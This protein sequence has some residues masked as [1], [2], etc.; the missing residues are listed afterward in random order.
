MSS[1]TCYKCNRTGHIARQCP[2]GGGDDRHS[3]GDRDGGNYGRGGGRDKCYKCNRF[4]H[5]ARD[6][7]EEQDRFVH[8]HFFMS[9]HAIRSM[10]NTWDFNH[11]VRAEKAGDL[12]FSVYL[13]WNLRCFPTFFLLRVS[14]RKS[15]P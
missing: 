9:C 1:N 13:P 12:A 2:Q 15:E 8:N 5:F 11:M 10:W 7:K 6:C 14:L 3:R 4:G